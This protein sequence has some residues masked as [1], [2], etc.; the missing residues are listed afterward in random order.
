MCVWGWRSVTLVLLC[1]EVSLRR[2]LHFG[3]GEISMLLLFSCRQLYAFGIWAGGR[4]QAE[5]LAEVILVLEFPARESTAAVLNLVVL[6]D[7]GRK[8]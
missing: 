1:I 7:T 4:S 8:P 5:V 3:G 6:T 2:C